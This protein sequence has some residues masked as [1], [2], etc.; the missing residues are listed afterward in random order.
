MIKPR[1]EKLLL[2]G[3]CLLFATISWH[4]TSQIYKLGS[5]EARTFLSRRPVIIEWDRY[6]IGEPLVLEN[7]VTQDT[8]INFSAPENFQLVD[9]P[10][11][12]PELYLKNKKEIFYPVIIQTKNSGLP[13]FLIRQLTKLTSPSFSLVFFVWL[14]GMISLGIS[15]LFLIRTTSLALPYTI[16]ACLTPQFILYSYSDY[17][18]TTFSLILVLG[19]LLTFQVAGNRR[20]FLFAGVLSGF[21]VYVKL[22]AI[23]FA[24]ALLFFYWEKIKKNFLPFFLGSLPFL[25]FFLLT[26]NNSLQSHIENRAL[27]KTIQNY[28]TSMKHFWIDL[29][30]PEV[31]LLFRILNGQSSIETVLINHQVYFLTLIAGFACVGY[32]AWKFMSRIALAKIFAFGIIYSVLI[33]AISYGINRD[34]YIYA[35]MG[36]YILTILFVANLKPTWTR[37]TGLIIFGTLLIVKLIV[38]MNWK[39]LHDSTKKNFNGCVWIYD[40]MIK[41]WDQKNLIGDHPLISLY[42]LDVGQIEFFSEENIIPIYLSSSL[43]QNPTEDQV[44]DFLKKFNHKEFLILS[45][46]SEAGNGKNLASYLSDENLRALGLKTYVLSTYEYPEHRK[47]YQLLRVVRK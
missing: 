22:S 34:F 5:F 7:L 37:K 17:P 6:K 32:L 1:F 16:L 10:E 25:I 45:S 41:D 36:A 13:P 31:G 11:G 4:F 43:T 15:L 24:P 21:T 29:I 18:D 47:S 3:F 26:M 38:L 14:S 9:D 42:F 12:I 28:I 40:C 46:N 20:A 35:A 19:I 39:T 23:F 8:F 33:A 30:S 44:L 27:P 2:A